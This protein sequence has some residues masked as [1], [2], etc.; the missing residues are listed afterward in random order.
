MGLSARAAG[1][2]ARASDPIYSSAMPE[3]E[4]WQ[5]IFQVIEKQT[6]DR[7]VPT[8]GLSVHRRFD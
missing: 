4:L 1:D 8:A 7:A 2:F 5:L 6:K 3:T